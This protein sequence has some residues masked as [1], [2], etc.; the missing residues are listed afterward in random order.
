[1]NKKT[2]REIYNC[3]YIEDDGNL[4]PLQKWYN[5]LIDKCASEITVSDVLKMIRQK[6]FIELAVLKSIDLLKYNPLVGELYDGELLEKLYTINKVNLQEH[7]DEIQIILSKAVIQ[8]DNN[9]WLCEEEREEFNSLIN[10][11]MDKINIK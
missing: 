11:F 4:Y 9:E 1:M 5:E 3:S 10:Q 8:S 7:Y 2:I 6:E